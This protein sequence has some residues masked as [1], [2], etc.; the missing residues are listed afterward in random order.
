MRLSINLTGEH[1]TITG[2]IEGV[3][4]V[5]EAAR[6]DLN[7]M[8]QALGAS[9]EFKAAYGRLARALTAAAAD[10]PR[11]N[12]MDRDPFAGLGMIKPTLVEHDP[13]GEP[14]ARYFYHPESNCLMR[15]E[16]GSHPGADGLVE[17]IDADEYDRVLAHQTA[18]LQATAPAAADEFEDLLS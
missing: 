15:T 18:V 10:V 9:S 11:V 8:A 14:A 3:L 1:P 7:A 4:V 13:Y 17:E 5:I 2:D 16:D 12:L 6:R